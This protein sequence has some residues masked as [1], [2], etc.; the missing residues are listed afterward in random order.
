MLW[1]RGS[2]PESTRPPAAGTRPSPDSRLA[3]RSI[4]LCRFSTITMAA[5]IIAPIAMAIPP[6]LMMLALIPRKR[7]AM[8]AMRMPMGSVRIATSAL[9]A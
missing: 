5:S 1:T 8:K 4:C 6:R 7:M 3:P 9:G 2:S